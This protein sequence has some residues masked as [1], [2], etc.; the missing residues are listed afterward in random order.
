MAVDALNFGRFIP[1]AATAPAVA[2]VSPLLQRFLRL[3]V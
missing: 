3:C 1:T 2:E